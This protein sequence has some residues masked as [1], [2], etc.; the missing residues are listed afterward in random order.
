MMRL[1]L[2]ILLFALLAPLAACSFDDSALDDR[3]ACSEDSECEDGLCVAGSCTPF[4]ILDRADAEDA[5]APDA[6]VGADG[7]DADA[8]SPDAAPP[9]AVADT[10]D[11][12]GDDADGGELVCTP[13]EATCEG[14][15]ARVCDGFGRSFTDT[16]CREPESCGGPDLGCRCDEGACVPR[17]CRPGERLCDGTSVLVCA[18]DG[19]GYELD[20]ACPDGAL[21]LGGACTDPTCTPGPSE[22]VGEAVVRCSTSGVFVVDAVCTDDD[23]RCVEDA[24]GAFC[25]PLTCVTGDVRCSRDGATVERCADGTGF[26]LDE[27]CGDAAYC[28]GARCVDLVCEP[29]VSRCAGPALR[30]VCDSDGRNERLEPCGAFTYCDDTSGMAQ[31][32][33]QQCVPLSSR[34]IEGEEA[35]ETCDSRGAGYLEPFPCDAESYCAVGACEPQVCEPGVRFCDGDAA[36]DCDDRGAS[37]TLFATCPFGCEAGACNASVCGDGIVDPSTGETCDDANDDACDGCGGCNVQQVLTLGAG[38]ATTSA[39]SWVPESSAFTIELWARVDADGALVGLGDATGTDDASLVVADGRARFEFRMGDGGEV[40]VTAPDALAPGWH[41]IAGVRFDVQGAALFV[42][43][44]LVAANRRAISLTGVDGSGR[45]WLGSDGSRPPATAVIDDV[46]ISSVAR[47]TR[48][49]APPATLT[50]DDGTIAAWD[51]DADSGETL[52][53]VGPAGRNLT[54]AGATLAAATCRDERLDAQACGDGLRASWEGCDDGNA[55]DGD[56]CSAICQVEPDCDGEAGPGGGCYLFVD[57]ARDWRD[58][59]NA[60]RGWGGDLVV[61]DN[62]TENAWITFLRGNDDRRWIGLNDRDREGNYEW[63]SGASSGYRA[64][65]DGEPNNSFFS[66]DCIEILPRGDGDNRGRWNDT[67]CNDDRR[68]ICER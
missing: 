3:P 27:D 37:S 51:F 2:P 35:F 15:V 12:G 6:D 48:P 53:D 50:V 10:T 16:D 17:A 26:V 62:D 20:E 28:D 23:A 49:F 60:C 55:V 47:Y 63:S 67:N 39:T 46:R 18:D 34:C 56:G 42:D 30:A 36:F 44:V 38:T 57:D 11:G 33:R 31:C 29:A 13:F 54:V 45:L 22:C 32:I 61:I 59:R 5:A 4:A 24:I 64:W 1:P 65:A 9:D 21:C 25:E 7:S 41:H 52:R 58:A 40:R 19:S 66:E 43:G 8:G 68:S 14:E